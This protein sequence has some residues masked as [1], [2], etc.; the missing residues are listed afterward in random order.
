MDFYGKTNKDFVMINTMTF[1]LKNGKEVTIDRDY[2]GYEID[3]DGNLGMTW[4][5]C[6]FWDDNHSD[7]PNNPDY[8]TEDE[9]EELV[10]AEL[11]E[12]NIEDDA[13]ADYEVE[14]INWD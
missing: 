12:V 4:Q 13:P 1:R 10:D 7:D 8:L 11:I 6:Y 5:G 9:L 14:I 2:T 3:N